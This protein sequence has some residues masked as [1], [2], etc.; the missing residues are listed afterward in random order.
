MEQYYYIY[1]SPIGNI[2]IVENGIGITE[3]SINKKPKNM[4]LK[5]TPLIK[6]AIKQLTE[7]FNLKRQSF[8]LPLS[9]SGTDFQEKVWQSLLKIPYGETKTYKEIAEDVN[10]P[11]GFR[12]VGL[13]N[14]KNKIMI[15]IP[16]HRVI[17]IN[18]KLVGYAG[19]LDIKKNLLDL[20][21]K[22]I[23]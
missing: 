1:K 2:I 7:Y 16:C 4:T 13:A 11:K 8:D 3:I 20:E 22:M 14:N 12:A 10:C 18:G 5:E 9:T 17:G 15:V 23:K 21:Q 19:G 6:E